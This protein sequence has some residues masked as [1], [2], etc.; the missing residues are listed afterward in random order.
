MSLREE[1][2]QAVR[3]K[4]AQT[5]RG[6]DLRAKDQ[7]LPQEVLQM[8][9]GY[10]REKQDG[11]Y[12]YSLPVQL[13]PEG[14]T[15]IDELV[16]IC[17][18]NAWRTSPAEIDEKLVCLSPK[19]HSCGFSLA[20]PPLQYRL[21]DGSVHAGILKIEVKK[22]PTWIAPKFRLTQKGKHA[23]LQ[24]A[25]ALAEQQAKE[26]ALCEARQMLEEKVLRN[27][28]ITGSRESITISYISEMPDR[29]SWSS[30]EKLWNQIF[31]FRDGTVYDP[32]PDRIDCNGILTRKL[33][34]FGATEF[35][36]WECSRLVKEWAKMA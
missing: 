15:L 12:G 20:L 26:A 9:E 11:M 23:A 28:A 2:D 10:G 19:D 16:K 30:Y 14:R 7:L 13:P 34:S 32:Y 5:K 24:E 17:P 22:S 36:R 4:N 8:Y 25:M 29:Q 6:E 31:I 33:T 3:E 21:A 35:L 27:S 1:Y 18:P